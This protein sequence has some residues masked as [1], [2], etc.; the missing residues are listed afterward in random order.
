MPHL[1]VS[2]EMTITH[3]QTHTHTHTHTLNCYTCLRTVG[4]IKRCCDPSVRLSVPFYD[5]AAFARW[6]YMRV[7]VS[8][9]FDR[10]QLGRLC[11]HPNAV[12]EGRH[13]ASP[14]DILFNVVYSLYRVI[15][16]I[17]TRVFIYNSLLV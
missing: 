8:N 5:S 10:G 16:E 13:I 17:G 9:A 1:S 7:T 6:R 3:T 12:S 4:G 11:P 2:L 15:L 14:R